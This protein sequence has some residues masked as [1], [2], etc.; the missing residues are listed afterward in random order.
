MSDAP[1]TIQ[2]AVPAEPVR[3]TIGAHPRARRSVRRA[4]ALGGLLGFLMTIALSHNA[5]VPAFDATARALIAGVVV[6]L[7]AWAIAVAVWKQIMLA[8]L[9]TVRERRRQRVERRAEL[10][11]AGDDA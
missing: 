3:I 6:H 1:T 9:E 11:R 4:R 8:E 10:A 5:G 7:A 2:P